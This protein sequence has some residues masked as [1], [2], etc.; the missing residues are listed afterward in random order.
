M[1]FPHLRQSSFDSDGVLD[2]VLRGD[3]RHV[4]QR[5]NCGHVILVRFDPRMSLII[6]VVDGSSETQGRRI[7]WN[8][9]YMHPSK[10]ES[11]TASFLQY[12]DTS[13]ALYSMF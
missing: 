7:Q 8:D 12:S 5:R 1:S 4:E 6:A 11:S 13:S 2:E 10:F 9:L 3:Q